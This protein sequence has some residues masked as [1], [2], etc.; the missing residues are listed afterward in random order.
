MPPFWCIVDLSEQF[1]TFTL[2]MS[3]T[4]CRSLD[5]VVFEV[6]EASPRNEDVLAANNALQ[7]DF[8]GSAI[9][10][11]LATFND[12]GFRVSLASF[13]EQASLES[14]KSFAAHTFKAGVDIA[15]C[16]D[17]ASPAV[18]SSMLMA[19]LEENGQRISTSLLRKRV[20]DDVCWSNADR[21]WRRSPYWLVLRVAVARYLLLVLGPEL[22]RFE[23]KFF[24]CVCLATFLDSAQQSLA[25]DEVHFLK[26]RLCRRLVKLDIA[27]N[28]VRNEHVKQH[29]DLLFARF[30]PTFEAILQSAAA[31]V[32]SEWERCKQALVKTIPFLPKRASPLDT[33]L[34]LSVS[35]PILRR[36]Q[37]ASSRMMA[38]RQSRWVPPR[39]FDLS[40]VAHE[41]FAEFAKPFLRAAKQEDQLVQRSSEDQA[42]EVLSDNLQRLIEIGWPLYRG[43]V[44]QMSILI[45]NAMDIWMW[46]DKAACYEFPLLRLYHPAFTPEIMNALHLA[47]YQ[48]MIRLQTIQNYLNDRI[49][50]CHGT[51]TTIFDNPIQGCFADRYYD[52][53]TAAAEMHLLRKSI[54]ENADE[55]KANKHE[56]WRQKQALY[57]RLRSQVDGSA[58]I[59]TVDENQPL[60]KPLHIAECCPRCQAERKLDSLR[61][62][63]HEDPLPSEEFMAKAVLF[64]LACPPTFASYRDA[65]WVLL[66]RLAS[67]ALGEHHQPKC[68]LREYSEL[69]TFSRSRSSITLASRTKS[70]KWLMLL[71]F[72]QRCAVRN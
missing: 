19:V 52:E 45:L 64:E 3:L 7:W 4:R 18:I 12:E 49:K 43:N 71:P 72:L 2:S 6:F 29:V 8:P 63:I 34:R 30:T 17:T 42:L 14:T 54:E 13:L 70:C 50:G 57:E 11:P 38:G 66:S 67:P 22:G 56:E 21:P 5:Q 55:K 20:R 28:A 23:Y 39:N 62:K 35:G 37:A 40:A 16:R 59:L 1:H 27:R 51:K 26:A 47:S 10:I 69:S 58:C 9:A 15:E 53:A 46:L 65:T 68:L 33:T 60:A 31:R 25:V 36:I 61:I 32:Q 48:E 41:Q 24:L 44:G